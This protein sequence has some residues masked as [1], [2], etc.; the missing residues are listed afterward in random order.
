[1]PAKIVELI[2]VQTLSG[3]QVLTRYHYLDADGVADEDVLV[4]DYVTD[5]VPLFI[6]FQ[7]TS[8]TH[9]AIRHRQ[10]FPTVA[11]LKE[12]PISP[13]VVG[14]NG[15]D[16]APSFA[17]LS[18]KYTI[19]DTVILDPAV[20]G[21]IKKGGKHLPGVSEANMIGDGGVA[22]PAIAAVAA[23][24]AEAK[25]PGTDPWQLIVASFELV[26]SHRVH[27]ATTETITKAQ[28]SQTVTKYAPVLAASPPTVSTQ[29][30]RKVLRGRVF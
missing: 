13:G 20:S 22:A 30:T 27:T 10:V 15:T 14:G 7:T 12:T 18:I 21:H 26:K 23:Y 3:Q 5:V 24:F 29:N 9:I 2:D 8:I 11:L 1:M 4:A 16:P 19:G 6:Q 25:D 17:T 28:M